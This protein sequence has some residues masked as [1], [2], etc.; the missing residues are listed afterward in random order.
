MHEIGQSTHDLTNGSNTN[1]KLFIGM[2]I[3]TTAD[4]TAVYAINGFWWEN[5]S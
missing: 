5:C 3:Q 4:G 2:Y 1:Q